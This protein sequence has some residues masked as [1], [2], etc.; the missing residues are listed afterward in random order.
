[1]DP[2]VARADGELRLVR[3]F[4]RV[5]ILLPMFLLIVAV[6]TTMTSL[7]TLPFRARRSRFLTTLS[8]TWWDTLRS[9]WLFWAGMVRLGFVI[10]GWIWE[11]LRLAVRMMVAGIKGLM[12]SPLTA[13]DW[14]TRNYFKP[15]VPWVAFLA[16]LLWCAV[17]A[18]IFMYTLSPTLTE[19]LAGIT[20]FEPN[21]LL[22]APILWIFLYLLI[23]GSFACIHVLSEAIRN[24]R[25]AEIVQMA[26]VELFVMFFEVLF[27]YRELVDAVT[28]WIAQTTSESVRLGLVSTLLLASF[29]WIGVR[30]MTWFLFGRFGT[31]AVLSILARDTIRRDEPTVS[32]PV[33]ASS[34]G[35][36]REALNAL[37]SEID[38]FKK[39]AKYAFEL[40][41]LPVLQLLAAAVNTVVVVVLG[42]PMFTLPFKNLNQALAATPKWP[43]ASDLHTSAATEL[44]PVAQGGMQ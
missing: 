12:R 20:G 1:M 3:V 31:P 22:M 32:V 10:V 7:Y 42:R 26:F 11:L 23:L 6:W 39:E 2:R 9:V 41:T 34:M 14:G 38:W 4:K 15:G 36:W 37:K 8:I 30:G 28:P 25:I 21:P 35:P 16:L 44:E 13:L 19:V 5:A 40:L 18:V 17:E 24:R 29:G 43:R 27:L 33:Q